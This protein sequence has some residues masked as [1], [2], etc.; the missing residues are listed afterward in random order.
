L[1]EII[2]DEFVCGSLTIDDAPSFTVA[3][4]IPPCDAAA[5]TLTCSDGSLEM[6]ACEGETI[7]ALTDIYPVVPEG[8]LL[9]YV[10][11][12]EGEIIE[13]NVAAA[14]VI[15]MEEEATYTIHPLIYD[16]LQINPYDYTSVADLLEVLDDEEICGDLG[17]IAPATYFVNDEFCCPAD[18]GSVQVEGVSLCNSQPLQVQTANEAV[19]PD[20]FIL[21]YLLVEDGAILQASLEPTFDLSSAV[22]VTVHSLVYD[23][24]LITLTEINTLDDIQAAFDSG[25]CGSLSS[26]ADAPLVEVTVCNLRPFAVNDTVVSF[27]E[28]LS[29]FVLENDFDPDGDSIEICDEEGATN[30]TIFNAGDHFVYVRNDGFYGDDKFRYTICD[31]EGLDDDADVFIKARKICPPSTSDEGCLAPLT[32]QQFCPEWCVFE[33]DEE[34]TIVD[35]APTFECGVTVIGNCV[36][37]ISIPGFTGAEEMYV[38]ACNEDGLCETVTIMFTITDCNDDGPTPASDNAVSDN[39]EPIIIDVLENDTDPQG[40]DLFLCDDGISDPAG[41]TASVLDN[42]ILFIPEEGFSGVTVIYYDLCD[43]SGDQ[44]GGVVFVQVDCPQANP[45]TEIDDNSAAKEPEEPEAGTIMSISDMHPLPAAEFISVDLEETPE[46]AITVRI[47]DIAGKVVF[48][49]EE[50]LLDTETVTLPTQNLHTG[51]YILQITCD[52]QA[53][54]RRFV[55]E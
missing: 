32:F 6:N 10:L 18:A 1:S 16:P 22:T 7:S 15:P 14:F 36:R 17:L 52:D 12:V 47:Y 41:G 49:M 53:C 8:F 11:V 44:A 55:K 34:F 50:V 19:V 33:D 27:E 45:E 2:A 5:G 25:I 4:C 54:S 39:C 46:E 40:D 43:S 24:A 37:Y 23:P 31:P 26:S 38:T 35:I 21:T 28:S 42:A 20:G 51:T 9:A 13:I 29:I 48:V 3:S 30:G